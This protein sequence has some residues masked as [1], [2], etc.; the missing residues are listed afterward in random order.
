MKRVLSLIT[1]LLLS[2]HLFAQ[3]NSANEI[4][5]A[6]ALYADGRIYVVV[7][8]IATI[9]TAIIVYLVN[10]DRKISKLEQQIKK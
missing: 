1:F 8:V 3:D 9:F 6:D 5:M 4:E 10:L 2:I 7:A